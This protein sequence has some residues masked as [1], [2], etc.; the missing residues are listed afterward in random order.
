L[1]SYTATINKISGE[2]SMRKLT[3]YMSITFDGVVQAP[4]RP[5]EDTRGGFK[6][7]GWAPPYNDPVMGEEAG[8]GMAQMPDLL[9]GRRTYEDFYSAWH[10]R[11]DNPFSTVLDNAQKYVVSTTLKE[12]LIWQNSTLLN[13]DAADVVAKLKQQAGKDLLIL[14]STK[15]V[16]SLMSRNLIDVYALLIHP[17]VLGSGQ[18]LF[19]EGSPY[20]ALELVSSKATTTGVILATYQPTEAPMNS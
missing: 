13:G 1:Q 4:G 20:T 9:F 6:Y 10:G 15:L 18:R 5:D 19:T 16:Q 11:T 8:K 3:V 2:T 14:G 17:L 12:P 7:G